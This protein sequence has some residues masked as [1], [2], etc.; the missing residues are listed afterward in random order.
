M[1]LSDRTKKFRAWMW[2]FKILSVLCFLVPFLTFAGV[3]LMEGVLATEAFKICATVIVTV[4]ISVVCLINKVAMRSKVW[5]FI[6][7]MYT[8]LDHF[9]PVLI[10]VGICQIIDEVI[11][12]PLYHKM[13]DIYIPNKEIDRR[14]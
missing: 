7:V 9:L 12:T 6:L 2:I 4:I 11:F 3:A 14:P 1:K 10:V 8:I 13:R 5:I